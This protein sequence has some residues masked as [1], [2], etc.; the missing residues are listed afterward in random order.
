[1]KPINGYK[2]IILLVL[3]KFQ[4]LACECPQTKRDTLVAEGLKKYDMVF[5]GEVISIDAISLRYK[6]KVT[7][8]FKGN[9]KESYIN[10]VT[11]NSCSIF[12]KKGYW[13]IY[14]NLEKN[15]SMYIDMCSSSIALSEIHPPKPP[16][17]LSFTQIEKLEFENNYLNKRINN[18][19]D[20]QYSLIK[21]REY[22]QLKDRKIDS[23]S[24][25][26]IPLLILNL[27]VM[28]VLLYKSSI[29]TKSP[30]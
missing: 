28:S 10:G 21:L 23:Y 14:A 27:L 24:W 8:L 9:C 20:W 4:T 3:V 6:I 12:P 29:S 30:Q 22:K 2:Y 1:M 7:E 11:N 15:N 26:I 5:Y 19:E 18:L 25:L 17:L 16:I 13:I